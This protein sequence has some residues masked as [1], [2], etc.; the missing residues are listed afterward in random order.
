MAAHMGGLQLG[1]LRQ[2]ADRLQTGHDLHQPSLV[3]GKRRNGNPAAAGAGAVAGAEGRQLGIG[4]GG[5][6]PLAHI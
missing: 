3:I 6:D 1:I 4:P 5:A 2:Q